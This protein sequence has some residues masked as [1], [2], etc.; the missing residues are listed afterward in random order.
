MVF[1]NPALILI[2]VSCS[3]PAVDCDRDPDSAG[4]S[5]T[6]R[7]SPGESCVLAGPREVL[8]HL[9]SNAQHH[10]RGAPL[11]KRR[12]M[13]GEFIGTHLKRSPK[14]GCKELLHRH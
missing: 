12:R 5:S 11:E 3:L 4:V 2:A 13:N 9:G 7:V 14:Q 1:I 10:R 6:D 8:G